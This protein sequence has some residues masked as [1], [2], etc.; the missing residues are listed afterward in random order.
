MKFLITTGDLLV[1]QVYTTLLLAQTNA[2]LPKP[3]LKIT[4]KNGYLNLSVKLNEQFKWENTKFES[5]KKFPMR[6]GARMPHLIHFRDKGNVTWRQTDVVFT[7][8]YK[9]HE[10]CAQD[11][12]D[13]YTEKMDLDLVG[14]MLIRIKI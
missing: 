10:T 13:Q 4:I 3:D 7:G 6:G 2:E 12:L 11:L 9:I 8:L 5:I 14:G 1:F